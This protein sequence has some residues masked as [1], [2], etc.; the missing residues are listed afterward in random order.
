M[1]PSATGQNLRGSSSRSKDK[2][3]SG[4]KKG[5]IQQF[6]PEQMN[7]FNSM[8]S[9]VSPDSYLSRL[10]GGDESMFNEIEAPALRQ[11]SGL[12]GNMASR[13]SGM[14]STGS[15]HSS[16]F[17]NEM[18]AASSNFAQDL[19]SRRQS[20]QQNAIKDLMGLSDQLLG[21]RPVD[22][23]LV[24]KPQR[25]EKQGWMDRLLPAATGAL[26]GFATGGPW[27]A[28][29]G[30]VTGFAGGGGNNNFSSLKGFNPFGSGNPGSRGENFVSFV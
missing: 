5:S 9:H 1:T 24:E 10:A 18:N 25:Q 11:F 23:F 28:V 19:A 6:T 20:L 2:I 14:G 26:T 4:Y 16:G 22:Q 17:Q 12:Q 27:G 21:Q 30:G 3:P 15:R 7:L 13:F 29:A 8:F